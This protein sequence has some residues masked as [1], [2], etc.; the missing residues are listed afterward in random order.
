MKTLNIDTIEPFKLANTFE[1]LHSIV[2]NYGK[3]FI[4]HFQGKSIPFIIKRRLNPRPTY[5]ISI[6]H[7]TTHLMRFPTLQIEISQR[8]NE[9]FASIDYINRNDEHNLSGTFIIE[10]SIK[11]LKLVGVREVELTDAASITDPKTQR[12]F[13]LTPYLLLKSS[14]TFYGK[15]GFT[16]T[17]V[18]SNTSYETTKE[19]TKRLCKLVS[20]LQ[21]QKISSIL[22]TMKKINGALS[23]LKDPTKLQTYSIL[24]DYETGVKAHE[25]FN[26]DWNASKI[27]RIQGNLTN[28]VSALEKYKN[29]TVHEMM[30]L[31][32]CE[33]FKYLLQAFVN[34]P[35][36][37]VIGKNK[38]INK[39][40]PIYNELLI[41]Y[42]RS[43]YVLDLTK[44]SSK[45]TCL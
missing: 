35:G 18:N 27:K 38:Y 25:Y 10:L 34:V 36:V 5:R 41:I 24:K 30:Q 28:I 4:V 39:Y 9:L 29:A 37:F 44:P 14:T 15:W 33:E 42:V 1:I 23:S 2:D 45:S 12:T 19:K 11:F 3:Q 22:N 43:E 32:S 7:T 8:S 17:L 20:Y 6:A 16:P 21:K 26:N 13:N 31:C 40:V